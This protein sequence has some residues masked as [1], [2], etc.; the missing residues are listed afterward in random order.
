MFNISRERGDPPMLKVVTTAGEQLTVGPAGKLIPTNPV[1]EKRTGT[2]GGFQYHV[3]ARSMDEARKIL[4]GLKRNHPEIDVEARLAGAEIEETYADGAVMHD[5]S[6]GGP[7]AGRS[8][9]K[10]CVAMAFA[11]GIDWVLC[12]S[13]VHYLR[14]RD[15]PASFGYYHEKDLLDRRAAGVPLHCLAVR[16][17]PDSGL[18]IAYAEYFGLYRIVACL[19]EGYAGPIVESS[20]TLDPRQ[21]AEL[22]VAVDLSFSQSDIEDIYAYKYA[23]PE[24][25]KQAADAVIGP[26]IKSQLDAEQQRVFGQAVNE[27]FATCGARP[28]E[29][30]TEEHVLRISRAVA[31]K[32]TPFILHRLRPVK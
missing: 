9:V 32:V 7:L 26:A 4:I 28:G 2:A 19:G 18:I 11:T 23:S 29:K 3:K 10:S 6:I 17:D 31:E 1:V 22:D 16:A 30:L 25:F 14:D 5:L 15:A 21:G 24:D 8:M 20:Y 13:A 12:N 27:A